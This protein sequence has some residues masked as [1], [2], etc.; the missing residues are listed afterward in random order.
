MTT[1]RYA[2]DLIDTTWTVPASAAGT[3]FNWEYDDGR[4]R[5]LNLYEKGKNS[6]WNTNERIDWSLEVDPSDTEAMPDELVSIYGSP[7]WERLTRAEKNE[8]RH[9]LASWL[10]SQFLHGEQGA[11]IC[12][13]KIVETVPDVDSKFYAA[14]QVMDEARHVET[15]ARFLNEK[16]ELMYPIS[17]NLKIL[18]EQTLTDARWDF[19]YLGMQVMIEGVALAA[20]SMVRDFTGDR[21]GKSINAYVMQDEARHV[22][23][24]RLALKDAYK[25]L[26]EAEKLEREEFVIEAA[27]LLRD[28]FR[29]EEVWDNL[30]LPKDECIAF[31]NNSE[32]MALFRKALFT[33]VVPCVKDI[34][35]WGPRVRKAFADM[36]VIELA[37]VDL[38]QLIEQDENIAD[39][40]D[41]RFAQ[42]K[43]QA[44]AR[45][46][47][48]TTRGAQIADTVLAGAE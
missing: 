11:L 36:G 13:A 10:N 8:V 6:Q 9:H 42:A 2:F 28:R 21:L 39:E 18:L 20:F 23:F 16:L 12:S 29:A 7:T 41:R 32:S 48:P 34:G 44:R 15:Y 47:G 46:G 45:I 22:A 43:E 30:G 3:F 19:I 4:E 31:M 38:D 17:P 33:R 24:G 26:T 35:L 40:M 37:D 25:Q 5:L 27:Y 1:D 14:T